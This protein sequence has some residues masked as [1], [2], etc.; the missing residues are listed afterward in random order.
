MNI[1]QRSRLLTPNIVN[2]DVHTTDEDEPNDHESESSICERDQ[3]AS[4][5]E[6]ESE[7]HDSAENM[8]DGEDSASENEDCAISERWSGAYVSDSEDRS[9]SLSDHFKAEDNFKESKPAAAPQAPS[10][11]DPPAICA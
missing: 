2:E 3:T 1:T 4:E 7:E 9:P 11:E 10:F 8:S 6:T 5:Y